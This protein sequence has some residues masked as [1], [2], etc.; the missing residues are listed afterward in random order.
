MEIA[1]GILANALFIVAGFLKLPKNTMT[2]VFFGNFTYIAYYYLIDLYSPML[3]V[4][5]GAI[6]CLIISQC[7]KINVIRLIA[8]LGAIITTTLILA[9]STSAHDPLLITAAWA[10]AIAQIN[11]NNYILY[12]SSVLVSQCLWITYC[13]Q[14]NEYAMLCTAGFVFASTFSS[15]IFYAY[16]DGILTLMQPVFA[17]KT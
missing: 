12:K 17:R 2:L 16:K 6:T 4:G 7:D 9:S 10:I 14:M 5:I 11:K 1:L 13:L 8:V 3:N 15:L